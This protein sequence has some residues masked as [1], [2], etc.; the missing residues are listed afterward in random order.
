[1]GRLG[2]RGYPPGPIAGHTRAMGPRILGAAL[3]GLPASALVLMALLAPEG[4]ALDLALH[5]LGRHLC[6]TDPARS[7]AGAPVCHRC[8]GIYAG[9]AVGGWLSLGLPRVPM[10]R[11]R[12]WAL[13]LVPLVLQIALGWAFDALDLWWLRV[14][15]GALFGAMAAIA[16][17]HALASLAPLRASAQDS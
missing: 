3:V 8:T 7:F 17:A 14:A 6:H 15:T 12:W 1:M 9:F 2:L 5:Q 13:A 16:L 4:S 11:P 10:E